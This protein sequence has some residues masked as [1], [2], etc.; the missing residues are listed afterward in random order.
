MAQKWGSAD[1]VVIF[2]IYPK[3]RKFFVFFTLNY[4]VG[5]Q[6]TKEF[7]NYKDI[8]NRFYE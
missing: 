6:K 1:C 4:E 8:Q 5:D 2:Q 3:T 7:Q